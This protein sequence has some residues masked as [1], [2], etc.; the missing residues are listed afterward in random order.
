ME[1]KIDY[2]A[3]IAILLAMLVNIWNHDIQGS[4]GWFVASIW[5]AKY[6]FIKEYE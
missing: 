1:K 4:L 2:V 3:F 6:F 5:C